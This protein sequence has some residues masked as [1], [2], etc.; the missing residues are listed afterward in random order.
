[1]KAGDYV[2]LGERWGKVV[3]KYGAHT[4]KVLTRARVSYQ[5]FDTGK[6]NESDIHRHDGE[7]KKDQQRSNHIGCDCSPS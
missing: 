6:V 5:D 3:R 7:I 2:Y 1:M 4:V